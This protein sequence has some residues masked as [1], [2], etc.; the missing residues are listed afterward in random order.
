MGNFCVE[1]LTV[2][3]VPIGIWEVHFHG[4]YVMMIR[5]EICP[6]FYVV[7]ATFMQN[8]E[9]LQMSQQYSFIIIYISRNRQLLEIGLRVSV[10]CRDEICLSRHF[11]VALNGSNRPRHRL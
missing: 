5:L 7:S 3:G 1:Q 9:V 11:A 4:L 10:L 8:A 2:G 6:L